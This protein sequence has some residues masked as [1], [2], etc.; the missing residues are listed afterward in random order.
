MLLESAADQA[1]EAKE[2]QQHDRRGDAHHDFWV[3]VPPHFVHAV[4]DMPENPERV[5]RID[6][7]MEAQNQ[8]LWRALIGVPACNSVYSTRSKGSRSSS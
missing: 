4:Q 2:R 6:P 3:N 7:T 5:S 8:K 1:S